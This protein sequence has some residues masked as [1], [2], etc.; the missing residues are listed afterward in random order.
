VSISRVVDEYRNFIDAGSSTGAASP[1][2]TNTSTN[3]V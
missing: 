1:I 2:S 3:T